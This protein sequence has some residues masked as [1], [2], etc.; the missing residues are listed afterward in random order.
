MSDAIHPT[1]RQFVKWF[2]PP[3]PAPTPQPQPVQEKPA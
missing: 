3:Q 1:M 2:A